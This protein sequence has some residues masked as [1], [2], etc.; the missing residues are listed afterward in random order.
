[1]TLRLTF[2]NLKVDRVGQEKFEGALC[3]SNI[4][5]GIHGLSDFFIMSNVSVH[6]ADQDDGY[7]PSTVAQNGFITNSYSYD[8]KS[9]TADKGL[10]YLIDENDD[11]VGNSWKFKDASPESGSKH[12][13]IINML[14]PSVKRLWSWLSLI[15][16]SFVGGAERCDCTFWKWH[17]HI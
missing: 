17:A 6:K 12:K 13:V 11:F 15:G 1:M 5:N 9:E 4:G 8:Q 14:F 2:S 3:T 16:S 7:K 10:S